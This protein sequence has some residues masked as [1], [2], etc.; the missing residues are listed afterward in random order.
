MTWRKVTKIIKWNIIE[1]NIAINIIVINAMKK[2]LKINLTSSTNI[3]KIKFYNKI[4]GITE[5]I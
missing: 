5:I 1:D 4:K 3:S 2:Y